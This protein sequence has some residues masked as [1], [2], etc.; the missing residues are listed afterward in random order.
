M[1]EIMDIKELSEVLE[2][3]NHTVR[4]FLCRQEFV[5]YA[6]YQRVQNRRSG[7]SYHINN[8]F[9]NDLLNLLKQKRLLKQ[10]QITKEL[11]NGKC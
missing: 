3:N 6:T 8:E 9:L 4:T 5:K 10:I 11:L 2:L 1:K 7:I